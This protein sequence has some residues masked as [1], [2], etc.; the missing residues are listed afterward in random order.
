[1]QYLLLIIKLDFVIQAAK[2]GH[3]EDVVVLDS[4]RGKNIGKRLV[5]TLLALAT[6]KSCYKVVLD[7]SQKNTTFYEKCG[8]NAAG[9]QMVVYLNRVD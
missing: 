8:M 5:D 9:M 3:I 1:M 7:C 2:L 6:A 4:M